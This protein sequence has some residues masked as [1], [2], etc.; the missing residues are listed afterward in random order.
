MRPNR[1][2]S[3]SQRQLRHARERRR[4]ATLSREA[5]AEFRPA[6]DGDH[7][8]RG[9]L[10]PDGSRCRRD[11]RIEAPPQLIRVASLVAQPRRRLSTTS[12]RKFPE[13]SCDQHRPSTLQVQLGAFLLRMRLAGTSG[14]ARD[15]SLL[16]TTILQIARIDVGADHSHG[17]SNGRPHGPLIAHTCSQVQRSRRTP[18][19]SGRPHPTG[20][21]SR[22]PR[23]ANHAQRSRL[24]ALTSVMSS[25]T[26]EQQRRVDSPAGGPG[27]AIRLT[28]L[29]SLD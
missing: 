7:H 16:T 18:L 25:P 4:R 10:D 15:V 11:L 29:E 19:M 24:E 21:V 13:Q 9:G 23:S 8:C 26:P 20:A 27:R 6:H 14:N 22:A 1:Q 28:G 5:R 2:V 12:V 3:L 17:P